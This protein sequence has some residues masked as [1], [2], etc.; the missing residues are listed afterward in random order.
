MNR[1]DLLSSGLAIAGAFA[2]RR[3]LAQEAGSSRTAIVIGV[4]KAGDLPVLRAA[5]TGAH[6]V[7]NWLHG[8]GFD[9]K[10]FLDDGKLVKA[11]DIFDAV[12]AVVSKGNRTQL[13]VYFAGHGFINS[14]SE[15]WLL[16]QAPVNPNEAISL[17][18]SVVLARQS[19][20]P[21]VVFISDA[22]RSRADSLRAER[23]R[24]SLIFPNDEA[25]S[26][27]PSDIDQFLATQVG[28]PS[29]EIPVSE[30]S[31]QYAGI[32]TNTFLDAYKHP[33]Q[34]MVHTVAGKHV[35]PNNQLKN[36][37]LRE[38]P[39]RAQR[40][41][42]RL[43][44]RPDTQVTS[45]DTT[46]IGRAE[47]PPVPQSGTPAEATISDVAAFQLNFVGVLGAVSTRPAPLQ[48][49]LNATARNTGFD[50]AVNVIADA[51]DLPALSTA[52]CGFTVSGQHLAG[53]DSS[54]AVK[55]NF[56]NGGEGGRPTALVSV[57]LGGGRAASI[58]LRFANGT[59]TVLAALDGFIGSVVLD[60]DSVSNVSYVP[61]Q[62]SPLRG[63]YI[64]AAKSIAEMHA[65]VATS[66]RFGV[67]RIE[68]GKEGRNAAATELASRIRVMKGVDPTLGIYAAYAYADAGLP[69]EVS[70][71]R[72]IL[73]G[74]LGVDIFDVAMLAG[75]LS[76]RGL[77]GPDGPFPCL[78]M[79]S[80]G[81]SLLRVR[82]V[83]LPEELLHVRDYLRPGLWTTVSEEGMKL[84]EA[85]LRKDRVR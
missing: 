58:A 62:S 13:V 47:N 40:A 75:A 19:G 7:A 18:E 61:S 64:Q 82:N 44:Q 1:R 37:L 42:I 32:Y 15:Y 38:V 17:V 55:T 33:D 69:G 10:E 4:D 54:P 21:N 31:R 30:S 45:G 6:D 2:V 35:V 20:I 24:G 73:H 83:R 67:F 5:K 57:E 68:G 71:V 43:N 25:S 36:F 22:C 56:T 59:G 53:T 60:G 72:E 76:G 12:N 65:V 14:Y 11:S 49:S 23:V 46:Y 81:W 3:I 77:G 66:A 27:N 78:P 70:S 28:L 16:S 50:R 84:V 39:R 52:R 29:Y 51:R 63:I 85:A 79:L 8:E 9:V 34:G 80:Q 74:D 48:E 41:S 26:A